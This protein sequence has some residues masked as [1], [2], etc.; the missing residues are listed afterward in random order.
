MATVPLG[1]RVTAKIDTAQE[2]ASR[3]AKFLQ[4]AADS[5]GVLFVIDH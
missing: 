4:L 3:A 5:K 2:G 1:N